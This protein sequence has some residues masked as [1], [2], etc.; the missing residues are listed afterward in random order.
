MPPSSLRQNFLGELVTCWHALNRDG[1]KICHQDLAW[2][3]AELP[4]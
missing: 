3:L 2:S 1:R 4:E